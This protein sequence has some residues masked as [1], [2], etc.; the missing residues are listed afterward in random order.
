MR[1]TRFPLSAALGPCLAMLL[2]AG[3]GPSTAA[4]DAALVKRLES[5]GAKVELADDDTSRVIGVVIVNGSKAPPAD[6][7][8]CG[9]LSGLRKLQV[10]DCRGVDDETVRAL[11]GLQ[12]LESL[13][14]TNT[15][16]TDAA[17]ET[18]ATAFPDLVELDLSSNP[19]L[20]GAALKWIA[21]LQKLERLGLMQNRFNDLNT[22]RLARLPTLESLDLR[23]NMEAG[24]LTLDVLG[25]L[26]HLRALKHRS[27]TV[28]DEGIER[29]A[30]SPSLTSLLAQDF[31]IISAAGPALGRI[32]TLESLEIFRC[33]GFGSAGV[34]ALGPLKK[35][36]RLTLRDLPEVD[37][38]ALTV[39]ADLPA[40]E[41]LYLHEIGSVGDAGL[42]RLAAVQGL[43][44]LDVWRLP[45]MTDATVALIAALP[46]LRELSIRET[47]VTAAC[48]ER[49]LEMP[50]LQSLTFQ[51]NGP[52]P[53]AIR[54]K[55]TA[56]KWKKLDLGP[57]R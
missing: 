45:N 56:R 25:K 12:H 43:E 54:A 27:T 13:S 8:A 4:D 48:L 36:V 31:S 51:D 15:T 39:L 23:G 53:D 34:T 24:D 10:A 28:T 49:I 57:A 38:A 55:V 18:I 3:A 17:V 33:Q 44:V 22:R 9:R 52:I 19:N 26:P 30:A 11:V 21:G 40:L 50:R 5:L 47:G 32:K 42:A 2:C 46:N 20:T 41:R 35:L 7:A 37:D 6:V 14:L 1:R 16:I 29:L